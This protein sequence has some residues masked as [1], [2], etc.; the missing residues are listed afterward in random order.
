MSAKAIC[1]ATGKGFLNKFL[2]GNTIV[3]AKFAS[4]TEDTNWNSLVLEHPWL[5]TEVRI[6]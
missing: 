5:K 2:D 1:E 3:P 6:L 4:V